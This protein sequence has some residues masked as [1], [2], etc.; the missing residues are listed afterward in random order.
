MVPMNFVN[1]NS[2]IKS[3]WP[4]IRINICP[5]LLIEMDIQVGYEQGISWLD[6]IT[7]SLF[8]LC[9]LPATLVAKHRFEICRVTHILASLAWRIRSEEMPWYTGLGISSGMR[10]DDVKQ[11]IR[12]STEERRR[13]HLPFTFIQ[14]CYLAVH[15]YADGRICRRCTQHVIAYKCNYYQ[16][17]GIIITI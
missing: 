7:W 1:S 13:K 2:F 5:W 11:S 9:Y 17:V 12:T 6:F 14:F 15:Y 3:Y 8:V 4:R 10:T 16:H